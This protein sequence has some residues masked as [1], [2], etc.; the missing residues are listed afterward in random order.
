LST[1]DDHPAARIALEIGAFL[2]PDIPLRQLTTPG[3]PAF[4]PNQYAE[5]PMPTKA[6]ARDAVVWYLAG[7]TG[8]SPTSIKDTWDLK[9]PPLRL[10]DNK[11]AYLAMSLRGYVKNHRDGATVSVGELRKA[12]LTVAGL[13]DLIHGKVK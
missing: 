2:R 5:E 8:L 6:E 13:A 11:L 10:D 7:F 9:G 1:A 3:V 12:A 4:R